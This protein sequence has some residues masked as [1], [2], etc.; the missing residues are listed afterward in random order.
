[1]IQPETRGQPARV[2]HCCKVL[3]GAATGDCSKACQARAFVSFPERQ[4]FLLFNNSKMTCIE[5]LLT[6]IRV[7]L[8]IHNSK[9]SFLLR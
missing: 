3:Q 9:F 2:A 4:F 8:Q 5:S 1:M 7:V 6:C